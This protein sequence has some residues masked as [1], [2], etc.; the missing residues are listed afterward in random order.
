MTTP[1]R[2]PSPPKPRRWLVHVGWA[3]LA[4]TLFM[5]GILLGMRWSGG[6]LGTVS[7]T[8]QRQENL[9]RIRI[10]LRALDSND[11]AE[12]RK[13]T[14]KL[15]YNAVLGLAGVA[16]YSECTPE[17]SDLI[18]RAKLRLNADMPP[19]SDGEMKLRDMAYAY[20]QKRPGKAGAP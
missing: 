3:L 4:M 10:A 5:A 1:I 9:G 20:C 11:P 18:A 15:L 8:N 7:M 14:T 17:E 19:R 13:G 12:L 16:R 6:T 2:N